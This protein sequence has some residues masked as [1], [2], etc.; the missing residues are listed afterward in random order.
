MAI[1]RFSTAEPGVKS[2]RFWDQDTQQ[3]AIVPI[4]SGN[5]SSAPTAIS[6]I[7]QTYQDLQ[8][9]IQVANSSSN[10]LSYIYFGS[11]NGLHNGTIMYGTGGG[12]VV[13]STRYTN[14]NSVLADFP[15][16]VGMVSSTSIY[17]SHKHEILNYT[18]T[19]M[20]KTIL[21]H[22]AQ[23]QN[24]TSGYVSFGAHTLRNTA[25]I[26]SVFI[27]FGG[28]GFSSGSNWTLYGIKAGA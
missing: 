24:S 9:V 14:D 3:G 19:T 20:H 2:N 5:I 21:S 26:S 17:S 25:A 8:L 18:N 11:N 15:S 22:V 1:R 13:A 27:S 7:P 4:A 12:G 28:G 10:F 16:A 23:D 6:N